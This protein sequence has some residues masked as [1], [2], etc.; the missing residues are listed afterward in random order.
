MTMRKLW[1]TVIAWLTNNRGLAPWPASRRCFWP[2]IPAPSMVMCALIVLVVAAVAQNQP[3]KT[4][5]QPAHSAP[6]YW[7]YAADP[8][9][10]T[11]HDEAKPADNTPQHVPNST[12]SFTGAQIGDLFSVPDWHPA[13]HPT[14]PEVVAHGSKPNADAGGMEPIGQRIIETPENLERTELR[15]DTSG[16]TAYVPV[17]SLKK[18]K[19]LVTTGGAGKTM[20]CATCHGADLK[21]LG[22]VPSIAGR[23]PSYI[24]RQLYDIQGGARAGAA[25]E[26]MQPPVAKLTLDDMVS[27][28]AYTASLHP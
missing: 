14:M 5:M 12:A 10:A 15:D 22:N 11:S 21:G 9:T 6:P 17:G 4:K 1:M 8:P 23:S 2:L 18:G 3:G 26:L 7:A 20:P 25:T 24:V 28:A 13:A 19:A 27:I 16:F